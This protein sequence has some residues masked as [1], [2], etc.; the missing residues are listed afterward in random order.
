M[1]NDNGVM[2]GGAL[3]LPSKNIVENAM[4]ANN[5]T[6][7]VAAVKAAGLVETLTSTGPFTVFAPTDSAF[8][9]LPAGTVDMLIKP[10]NK[11]KLTSI[12]TYHVVAGAWKSTDLKEGEQMVKS[13]QGKEIKITKKDGKVWVNNAIVETADVI[14]SNGVTHVIDTVLLP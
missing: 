11:E 8:N 6:S 9:K 5:V 7:V 1:N 4:M 14:S 10:E 12:L 2:V 13:V 3:M